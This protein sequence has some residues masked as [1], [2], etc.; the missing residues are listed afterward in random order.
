MALGSTQ[1]LKETTTRN[2]PGG[3]KGGRCVRLTTL[4]PSVSRLSRKCGSLDVPKPYGP[5]RPVTGIALLFFTFFL[6]KCCTKIVSCQGYKDFYL[7]IYLSIYLAIYLNMSMALQPSV[8]PQSLHL[9]T[10]QQKH[11]INAHKHSCLQEDSNA[12][13]PCSSGRRLFLP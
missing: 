7:S 10:E 3:V 11:R 9:Y 1:P 5:P 13:P 2:L 4:P 8:G 12:Q 6:S